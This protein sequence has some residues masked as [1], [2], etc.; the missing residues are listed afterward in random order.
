MTMETRKNDQRWI[1][2]LLLPGQPVKS[3]HRLCFDLDYPQIIPIKIF[4]LKARIL[5]IYNYF[6]TSVRRTIVRLYE[7]FIRTHNKTVLDECKDV[8]EPSIS[9]IFLPTF[10]PLTSPTLKLRRASFFP[11]HLLTFSPSYPPTFLPSHLPTFSPSYLLPSHL[12]TLSTQY[13]L[14]IN[15][16]IKHE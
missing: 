12:L 4:T 16:R 9:Y 2:S 8:F 14:D 6:L 10:L 15:K 7:E 5:I 13:G 3:P 11:S 1:T